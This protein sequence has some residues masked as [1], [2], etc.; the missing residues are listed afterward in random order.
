[1]LETIRDLCSEYDRLTAVLAARCYTEAQQTAREDAQD[2]RADLSGVL[3]DAVEDAG[4]NSEPLRRAFP[5]RPVRSLRLPSGATAW[6]LVS[7][8]L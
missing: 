2:R 5:G 6:D 3:A 4:G 7:A 1:M 8:C